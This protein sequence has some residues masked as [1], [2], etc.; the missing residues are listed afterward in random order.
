M[1]MENAAAGYLTKSMHGAGTAHY[2]YPRIQS[3]GKTGCCKNVG[4]GN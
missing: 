3:E 4:A 2:D 1:T